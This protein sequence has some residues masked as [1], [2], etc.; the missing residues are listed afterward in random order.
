MIGCLFVHACLTSTQRGNRSPWL[1]RTAAQWFKAKHHRKRFEIWN[2]DC[3]EVRCPGIPK[4]AKCQLQKSVYSTVVPSHLP[5]NCYGF[6]FLPDWFLYSTHPNTTERQHHRPKVKVNASKTT[7]TNACLV[8][9]GTSVLLSSYSSR[10]SG[11]PQATPLAASRFPFSTHTASTKIHFTSPMYST[12]AALTTLRK[13]NDY[14]YDYRYRYRYR[15]TTPQRKLLAWLGP[16]WNLPGTTN[17]SH[18][19]SR[20][21]LI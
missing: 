15:A 7:A 4:I 1:R 13:P 11:Y 14:D 19:P 17:H 16:Y 10:S 18:S 21:V 20:T 6:Q 3:W 2:W 9:L 8:F 12:V 5:W